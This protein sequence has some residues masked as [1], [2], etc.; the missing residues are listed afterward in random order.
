MM[1]SSYL[2]DFFIILAG[3]VSALAFAPFNYF[4]LI[5]FTLAILFLNWLYASPKRAAWRGF[6]FGL[7]YF[8]A[9]IS[10]VYVSMHQFGGLAWPFAFLITFGFVLLLS[11]PLALQGYLFKRFWSSSFISSTLGFASL[12][13]AGE[14]LR[15]WLFTGFPWLY[16]GESQNIGPLAGYIPV[17]GIFGVSFFTALLASLIVSVFYF[18]KIRRYIALAILILIL[19]IGLALKQ[20]T[21][22]QPVGEPVK[23]SLMQG[24]IPQSLKWD[25]AMLELSMHRYQAFTEAAWQN[26]LIVWPENAI[27]LPLPDA[28]PFLAPLNEQAK[29]H[30][31]TILVGL[32]IPTA[33]DNFYY[34]SLFAIGK[35]HGVYNKQHLVPFGEYIPFSQYFDR[36]LEFLNIPM[37]GFTP[38]KNNQPLLKIDHL[39][40]APFIC[41]EIAYS[42]LVKKVLPKANLLVVISDDAWFGQSNAAWQHLQIA[43]SEALASGRAILFATNNGVTAIINAQ[44]KIT[45]IA[46]RFVPY[47]LNG[48]VQAC[49]GTTIW[50]RLGDRPIV[51]VVFLILLLSVRRK[52]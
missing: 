2:F 35:S 27:P 5:Y 50:S 23:V 19:F 1:K 37:V 15:A 41:Y 47:I 17:F 49:N 4:Y 45:A 26:Q 9:G 31:A 44:G 13:V 22:T 34:N 11:T 20:I 32:P 28:V 51:V 8:G 7:G 33:D 6:L 40:I 43:Q 12:L 16:V 10:W 36:L 24:N 3:A 38:G 39:Q 21:W 25:P 14:W 30:H 42:N 29:K 48:T 46:P 52:K 18:Q